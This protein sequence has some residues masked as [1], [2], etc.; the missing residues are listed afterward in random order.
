MW[1]MARTAL[2]LCR[3]RSNRKDISSYLLYTPGLFG[4]SLFFEL[5]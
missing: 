4:F 5:I 2:Q 1:E 3:A